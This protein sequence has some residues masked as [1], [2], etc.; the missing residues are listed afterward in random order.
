[1]KKLIALC[2]LLLSFASQATVVRVELDKAAY[3]PDELVQA[4][5][6]VSGYTDGLAGFEFD[7]S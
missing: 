7:L 3:L 4:T 5:V 6:K 1:M 2:A